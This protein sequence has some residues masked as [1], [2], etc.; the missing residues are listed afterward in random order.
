MK[1]RFPLQRLLGSAL[2][3]LAAALAL[4]ARAQDKL[5]E[6]RLG[7]GDSIRISVFQNPNLTLETRVTEDGTITYPLIGKVKIGGMTMAAAEQTIAKALDEGNFIKQPQVT[8][9]SLQIR[10][11][12]VS[13][14]GL[15]FRA[16][17]FPL[18][19]FNTRVSEMIALAGGITPTGAD[20]AIVTG[21]RAGKPYRKEIDIAALFLYNRVEDDVTVAAG[22]VIYV[23]RAPVFY[24]YGE[25]QR[26]GSYRV[27]RGMSVRQALVQGG[28]PTQ[29]G[30][31][32]S[33]R[34]HRRGANNQL[35][36]I[37]P[38][39]DDPIQPD[40]VLHVGESLF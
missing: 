22:D 5:P 6:Y 16:G 32:R 3:I 10:S 13:V 25:V 28:G 36:V 17:R 14:L 35:E 15:V 7:P 12:Q 18:E 4:D 30:T 23:H 34:L 21:Q 39:L 8:I 19:T 11:S 38:K 9:L 37:N 24:V 40:D 31:E 26:P 2:L 33:V 20:V 1:L 27:E 29:R